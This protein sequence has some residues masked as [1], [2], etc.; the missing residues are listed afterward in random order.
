M[1]AEFFFCKSIQDK[2]S[3]DRTKNFHLP[4]N[5]EFIKSIFRDLAAKKS[6]QKCLKDKTQNSNEPLKNIIWRYF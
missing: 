2:E 6:L 5:M 4:K 1:H 3:Y